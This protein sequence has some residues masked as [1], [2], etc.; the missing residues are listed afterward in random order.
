MAEHDREHSVVGNCVH[1]LAAVLPPHQ[2]VRH[3]REANSIDEQ[4]LP[5][6]V[7]LPAIVLEQHVAT[8]RKGQ[9][10]ALWLVIV[11]AF[12]PLLMVAIGN[13]ARRPVLQRLAEQAQCFL[14]TLKIIYEGRLVGV[15]NR[16]RLL[17]FGQ[18]VP[19]CEVTDLHNQIR[20]CVGDVSCDPFDPGLVLTGAVMIVADRA[21][22][23]RFLLDL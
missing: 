17:M 13:V 16:A 1:S 4:P 11:P 7:G 18:A 14:C 6:C 5:V 21:D 12:E 3:M 20:V 22:A 10:L 2:I 8:I 23:D 19:I 9:T 15:A